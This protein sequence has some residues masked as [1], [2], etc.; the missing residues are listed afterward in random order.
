MKRNESSSLRIGRIAARVLAGKKYVD[1]KLVPFYS[2]DIL[3]L[4]A[5]CLTQLPDRVKR[6]L[7][8]VVTKLRGPCVGRHY[9]RIL[10][11]DLISKP[12]RR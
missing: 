12:K 5:S 3:A 1:G 8:V 9:G 7:K 4:A 10:A 2:D 6:K 11:D